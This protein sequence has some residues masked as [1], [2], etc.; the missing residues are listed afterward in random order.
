MSANN[1]GERIAEK[2]REIENKQ[3]ELNQL[4]TEFKQERMAILAKYL[5]EIEDFSMDS[6]EFERFCQHL[7]TVKNKQQ[8]EK[9]TTPTRVQ[10]VEKEEQEQVVTPSDESIKDKLIKEMPSADDLLKDKLAG[11]QDLDI[12]M[13]FI[14]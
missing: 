13:E 7:A 9:A 2:Q 3:N 8:E 4:V 14:S 1:I 6:G 5:P 10:Q 12:G 11:L